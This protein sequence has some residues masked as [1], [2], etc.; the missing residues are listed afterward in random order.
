MLKMIQKLQIQPLKSKSKDI[1]IILKD[2]DI[3]IGKDVN[4]DLNCFSNLSSSETAMA[5]DTPQ[6]LE[7]DKEKYHTK[8]KCGPNKCVYVCDLCN[9]R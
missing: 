2:F 6:N 5:N 8:V 7:S 9:E 3:Q 1:W 4:F